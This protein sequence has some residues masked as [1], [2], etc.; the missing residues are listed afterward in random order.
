[1]KKLIFFTFLFVCLISY[2]SNVVVGQAKT[3]GIDETL[4]IIR[5]FHPVAKQAD[6]LISLANASLQS[7]RGAFDPAI[8]MRNER[9]TFDGKNYYSYSNPELKIPTWFGIDLKAGFENNNGD[10]MEPNFSLGKSSYAGFSFPV[11]KNL[12]LDNRRAA[13]QQGKIMVNMSS[14]ERLLVVNDLLYDAADAYWAWV[15]AHQSYRILSNTLQINTARFEN[16]KQLFIG[17][18][19]AAIDT[20]EALSQLQS[21]EIMQLQSLLNLQ[22]Q[23]LLLSNFLWRESD[24][25]FELTE[26]IIPD[27]SW[28]HVF[29]QDYPLPSLVDAI[30]SA[31]I[32]HPKLLMIN[33]KTDILEVDRRLKFQGL[34]PTFDINYNFLNKGYGSK[35]FFETTLFQNN[36]KYGFQFGLPLLQRQSRGEYSAA[37][38]KLKSQQMESMQQRLEIENKVKFS[39]NELLSLQQQVFI[40]DKNVKNQKLL[41]SAEETKFSIGESSL[42]LIN[43]RENKLL[44]SEQ[45][46]AELKTKFF[47]SILSVQWSAGQLR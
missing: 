44:E 11:L 46:L 32:N 34:L 9:K 3:L 43:S 15:S 41:L 35:G 38:I 26:D 24:T 31:S 30:L 10:R 4:N 45:K 28:N 39:F 21:I 22:K 14:Q 5:K 33:F 42:F 16:T 40:F 37:K 17:G 2:S 6:L 7:S 47:K 23:R 18:D 13:L 1:M 19:R 20:T 27:S 8:Y 12:L 36:Y 25:P 29:V